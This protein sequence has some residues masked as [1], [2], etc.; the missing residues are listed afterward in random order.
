MSA[1]NMPR[2]TRAARRAKSRCGVCN[3]V[4]MGKLPQ[5]HAAASRAGFRRCARDAVKT[6]AGA[7]IVYDRNR[8]VGRIPA[9]LRAA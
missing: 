8:G 7:R 9:N 6:P 1:V 2:T 5:A 4:I 3:R